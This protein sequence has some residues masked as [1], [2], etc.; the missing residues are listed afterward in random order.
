MAYYLSLAV[1]GKITVDSAVR[2]ATRAI[3]SAQASVET[4]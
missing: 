3:Q 4:R 2:E 1:K